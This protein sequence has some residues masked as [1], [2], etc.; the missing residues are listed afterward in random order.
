VTRADDPAIAPLGD[1][2]PRRGGWLS[3]AVG[4][5][6]LRLLGWRVTGAFPNEPKLVM[7]GAP[8][9]SNWDFVVA[10]AAAASIQLGFSWVGKHVL[11]RPLFGWFFR[12]AGGIPVDRRSSHGF[13][14]QM[15]SAFE[16]HPRLLLAIAPEGTRKAVERWR[17]G[18]YHIAVGA[19]VPIL[20]VTFDNARKAIHIGPA[21]TPSG[22]LATD[23]ERILALYAERLGAPPLPAAPGGAP[24]RTP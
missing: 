24:S 18:F 5:A 16:R 1:A 7:I 15:V 21:L 22:D 13:V 2:I 11:F 4:R 10:L 6:V 9:T 20:V 17:T 8:H 23:L 12:L 19:R 3:R 14:Q